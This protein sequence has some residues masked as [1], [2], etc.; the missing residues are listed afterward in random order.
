MQLSAWCLR[1]LV[2]SWLLGL[3]VPVEVEGFG[4]E[5][6]DGYGSRRSCYRN[7]ERRLANSSWTLFH[8]KINWIFI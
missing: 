1:S 3:V 6:K 4:E 8:G 5:G 2:P 7:Q